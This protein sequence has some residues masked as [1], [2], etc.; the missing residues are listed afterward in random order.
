MI[1]ENREY[2]TLGFSR[3]EGV[4]QVTL[5]RPDRL[6]AMNNRMFEEIDGLVADIAADESV[7]VVI[8]TGAGRA[9]CAGREISELAERAGKPEPIRIPIDTG[10]E[11]HFVRGIQVP[12][13]AAINGAAAGS[14]FGLA[15]LSDFRIASETA[16]FVEAHVKR[17]LTPSIAAWYL[18]KL[19]GLSRATEMVLLDEP[20]S[21]ADA[22]AYGM[23]NSVVPQDRVV[24][25]A[26]TLARR[27][28]ALP[29]LTVRLAKQALALGLSESLAEVRSRAG[30]G[31]VLTRLMTAEQSQASFLEKKKT[32]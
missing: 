6:N 30:W 28:E 13:I 14:G 4:V 1:V 26:W 31:Q 10:L 25:E 7:R 17:G 19:V 5:N 22:L 16:K 20:I 9:F 18:P 11:Y 15:L 32:S 27:L 21:A 3:S 2:E 29:P 12:I 23:V 24:E 8:Y